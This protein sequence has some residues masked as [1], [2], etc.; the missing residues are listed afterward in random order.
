MIII[1]LWFCFSHYLLIVLF[2]KTDPKTFQ[3]LPTSSNLRFA[4][5]ASS[6]AAA[7]VSP[8]SWTSSSTRSSRPY[9]Q[10]K[11]FRP[12]HTLQT[13]R[14]S[15][16]SSNK[17]NIFAA[18]EQSIIQRSAHQHSNHSTKQSILSIN[19]TAIPFESFDDSLIVRS[20]DD[21]DQD[22][23]DYNDDNDEEMDQESDDQMIKM[24]RLK[25]ESSILSIRLIDRIRSYPFDN[26]DME[27]NH[28]D[29]LISYDLKL[30]QTSSSSLR[31]IM[32]QR[33]VIET[34]HLELYL[35]IYSSSSSSATNHHQKSFVPDS[36]SS[37]LNE[38]MTNVDNNGNNNGNDN[39]IVNGEGNC[40]QMLQTQLLST[41]SSIF[42]LSTNTFNVSCHLVYGPQFQCVL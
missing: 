24:N 27:L 19:N 11:F 41:K 4:S 17:D 36:S 20:I 7:L 38:S 3:S 2:F 28:C 33:I 12:F 40:R 32:E 8:T 10:R 31:P 29:Q 23:I 26:N 14:N 16:K 18:S 5:S 37:S 22:S 42:D 1:S 21:D 6:A 34:E 39:D 9:Y 25:S 13:G 15:L 30:N 35:R